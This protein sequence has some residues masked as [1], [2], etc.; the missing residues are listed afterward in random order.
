MRTPDEWHVH[1]QGIAVSSQPLIHW[2]TRDQRAETNNA[3]AESRP[4]RI[5]DLTRV[6]AGPVA[7]RFLAAFGMDVL[8][9][10]PP[11]WDEPGLIPEVTIGKRCAYLDL[12]TSGGRAAFDALLKDADVLVHGLRPGALER[13]G[14]HPTH[15]RS[16]NPTLIDVAVSAYGTAG[17]WSGRRGF[18]SLVQ[19]SCGIALQGM[20]AYGRD[21]PT[22]LPVQ[23]LDH[24]TGYLMAAAVARALRVRRDTGAV[25][26]AR[27]SLA[28]T[29][30]LLMQ[31]QVGTTTFANDVRSSHGEP[32]TLE[33]THWGQATRVAFPASIDAKDARWRYPA[34]PLGASPAIW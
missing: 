16:I 2:S 4:P 12:K 5:L 11:D 18:D 1:P 3:S 30:D 21:R 34:G 22:P 27:L 19:M 33:V 24:A 29:A 14:Y 9:I 32:R 28:R 23:A 7:T 6:L 25:K 31:G 8:R 20:V 15:L 26:S 10:D 13:L 17:P